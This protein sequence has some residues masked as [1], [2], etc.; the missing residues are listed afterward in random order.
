PDHQSS[1][2]AE[3]SDEILYQK[4]DGVFSFDRLS[5]VYLYNIFHEE[6]QQCHLK[7]ASQRIPFEQNLALYA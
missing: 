1:I 3:N 6:D 2:L 7:I 4:P 5:S